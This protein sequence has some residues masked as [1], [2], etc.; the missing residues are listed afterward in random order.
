MSGRNVMQQ[1]GLW[2]GF[3]VGSLALAAN[4]QAGQILPLVDCTGTLRVSAI[5]SFL[6]VAV[7]LTA[8][9]ASWVTLRRQRD[10]TS[11]FTGTISVLAALLFSFALALQGAAALV[12]TGCER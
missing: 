3:V 5:V 12:L 1:L 7:T 2:S 8:G 6:G 9:V 11:R 10:G 4:V